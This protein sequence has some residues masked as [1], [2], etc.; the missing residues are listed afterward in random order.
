MDDVNPLDVTVAYVSEINKLKT[1]KCVDYLWLWG[2]TSNGEGQG[3]TP[4]WSH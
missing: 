2:Y 3:G 1:I 4:I